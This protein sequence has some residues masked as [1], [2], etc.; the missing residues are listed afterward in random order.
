MLVFCENVSLIKLKNADII[1]DPCRKCEKALT[2]QKN[3]RVKMSVFECKPEIK[4]IAVILREMYPGKT[5]HI[6]PRS[7]EIKFCLTHNY[8]L[9]FDNYGILC[10]E[11]TFE[12]NY[13]KTRYGLPETI[14]LWCVTKFNKK[15]PT[16]DDVY[17]NVTLA[18]NDRDIDED[19][20]F[21]DNNLMVWSGTLMTPGIDSRRAFGGIRKNC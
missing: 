11:N 13:C 3:K 19:A 16:D 8:R 4:Q 6:D 7:V 9:F 2:L 14:L 5:I 21:F 10:I 12:E 15:I 17:I 1:A 18:M 20:T